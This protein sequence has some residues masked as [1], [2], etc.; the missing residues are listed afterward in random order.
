[1][2]CVVSEETEGTLG[3]AEVCLVVSVTAVCGCV[4]PAI[5]NTGLSG[6]FCP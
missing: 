5:S 2:G 6:I 3:Y 4:V 1:M